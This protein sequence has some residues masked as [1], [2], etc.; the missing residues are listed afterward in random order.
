VPSLVELQDAFARA[1]TTGDAGCLDATLIGGTAPP[2][3]LRIHLRHYEASLTSALL[4]KFPACAWLLGGECVREAARAYV[5]LVP[6]CQ[7]CIAEYGHLFPEFLAGY[8]RA[9]ALPYVA[10]FAKLEWA[11]A[12]ASIATGA[13]PCS[14]QELAS[15]S[16]ERLLDSA[17]ALQPG[18]R[19]C[20]SPWRVDEL[21]TV[22][23]EGTQ[24][25]RF[26][27]ERED[28]FIEIRGARGSVS[29]GRLDGAA[30]AFRSALNDGRSIGDAAAAALERDSGFDAGAA[31]KSLAE[32]GLVTGVSAPRSECI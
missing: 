2:Q 29:L 19:Y 11:F 28:T 14:W 20:E 15:L 9:T 3:R 22:Y 16:V 4:E 26:V 13:A 12:Q 10:S 18:L 7:P 21:L 6:P 30:F 24:P 1:M 32:A 5:H 27:L 25:E 8:G 31:L 17:L 23:L